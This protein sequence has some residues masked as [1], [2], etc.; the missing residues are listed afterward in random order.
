[1]AGNIGVEAKLLVW[2]PWRGVYI[3]LRL[4]RGSGENYICSARVARGRE[5]ERDRGGEESRN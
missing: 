2:L 4:A 3:D 5:R 1:M